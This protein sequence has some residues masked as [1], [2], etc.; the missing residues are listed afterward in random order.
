M[1]MM[2]MPI[3]SLCTP[4]SRSTSPTDPAIRAAIS[5]S[6][7][8]DHFQ[9]IADADDERAE[10]LLV[11]HLPRA[12]QALAPQPV[13]VHAALPIRAGCTEHPPGLQ[14]VLPGDKLMVRH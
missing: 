4:D 10:A 12:G 11:H 9:V 13:E 14:L 2:S 1:S 5:G 3:F 8:S 7:P 6:A